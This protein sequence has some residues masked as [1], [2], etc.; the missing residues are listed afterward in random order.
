MRIVIG[1]WVNGDASGYNL[2]IIKLT[3]LVN[4]KSE[5]I[6]YVTHIIQA[7]SYRKSFEE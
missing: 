5:D 3:H 4:L 2:L 6:D 1:R 7:W